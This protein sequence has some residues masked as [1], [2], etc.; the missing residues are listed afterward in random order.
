[1]QFFKRNNLLSMH[2]HF[3]DEDL[4]DNKCIKGTVLSSFY[5]RTQKWVDMSWLIEIEG[6]VILTFTL[7]TGMR[8]WWWRLE[9]KS[10]L[11]LDSPWLDKQCL[12]VAGWRGGGGQLKNFVSS[13]IGKYLVGRSFE[14]ESNLNIKRWAWRCS[15]VEKEETGR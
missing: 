2:L 9:H 7:C 4:G 1:M 3:W 8:R 14:Q 12:G 11:H 5:W 6:G 15:S 13:K 10:F